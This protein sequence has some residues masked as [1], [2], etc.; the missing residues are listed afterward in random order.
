[1]TFFSIGI[2]RMNIALVCF[3]GSR[4]I[5]TQP[6]REYYFRL[7]TGRRGRFKKRVL[8][9][10]SIGDSGCQ[11]SSTL[12]WLFFQCRNTHATFVLSIT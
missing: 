11:N 10:V 5:G 1:M 9:V 4:K 8:T 6:K 7:L 3:G 12:S 2:G